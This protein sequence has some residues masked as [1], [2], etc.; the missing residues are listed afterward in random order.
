MTTATDILT[1]P[2]TEQEFWEDLK[3]VTG[4]QTDEGARALDDQG[5]EGHLGAGSSNRAC[6]GSRH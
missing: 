3:L 4:G 2:Y 6:A 1:G 5:V